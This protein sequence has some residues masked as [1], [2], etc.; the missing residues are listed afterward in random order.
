M[1]KNSIIVLKELRNNS[2]FNV[3]AISKKTKLSVSTVKSKIRELEDKGVI[4]KYTSLINFSAMNLLEVIFFFESNSK[5][6]NEMENIKKNPFM[7]TMMKVSND[8][9]LLAEFVFPSIRDYIEFKEYLTSK[10][11]RFQEHFIIQDLLR[12]SF[13]MNS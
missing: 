2:R 1:N 12:E 13:L 4:K 6:L 11:V 10:K 5:L 9:G 3:K 7:N 8:Y